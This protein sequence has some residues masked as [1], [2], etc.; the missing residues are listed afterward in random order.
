MESF[1]ML[2]SVIF[3]KGCEINML[4]VIYTAYVRKVLMLT[5]FA[6][7]NAIGITKFHRNSRNEF[8]A[9]KK[10]SFPFSLYIMDSGI[11]LNKRIA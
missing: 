9:I 10:H 3:T 4:K 5:M 8:V 6:K 1:Q 2:E 11:T 7:R